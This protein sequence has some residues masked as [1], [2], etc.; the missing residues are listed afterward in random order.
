MGRLD[1][2]ALA[3][4]DFLLKRGRSQSDVARLLGIS[5]GAVRYRR[6]HRACGAVDGRIR[7][8]S[9]ADA[10]TGAIEVWRDTRGQEG[11]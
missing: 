2:E 3:T 4:M 5:E 10:C 8:A 7:Q 11:G 1:D 6:R 9:K